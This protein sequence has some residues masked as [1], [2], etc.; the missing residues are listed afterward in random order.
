MN[1]KEIYRDIID[2]N[3]VWVLDISIVNWNDESY[4]HTMG[5]GSNIVEEKFLDIDQ[6][7]AYNN[8]IK[9]AITG[10]VAINKEDEIIDE[11]INEYIHKISIA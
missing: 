1:G 11:S 4:T 10:L 2:Y 9:A 5:I 3:D 8:G 7:I 6:C